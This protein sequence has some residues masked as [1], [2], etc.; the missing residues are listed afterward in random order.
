MLAISDRSTKC[1]S[2]EYFQVAQDVRPFNEL[3]HIVC[4][5]MGLPL[6]TRYV[7]L[8]SSISYYSSLGKDSKSHDVMDLRRKRKACLSVQFF[9]AKVSFSLGSVKK[10]MFNRCKLV[11]A[12]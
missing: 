7:Y 1:I 6:V 2:K 9:F 8:R 12:D 4:P 11:G 10:R 5:S 3:V